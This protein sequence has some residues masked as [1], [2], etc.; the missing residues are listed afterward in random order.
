MPMVTVGLGLRGLVRRYSRRMLV[1]SMR[2]SCA[3]VRVIAN[4]D[5]VST[6]MIIIA[7]DLVFIFCIFISP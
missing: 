5:I 6:A 1:C 7:K 4:V 2:G 3:E